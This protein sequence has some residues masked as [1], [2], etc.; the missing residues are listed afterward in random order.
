MTIILVEKLRHI[1]VHRGGR[2]KSKEAFIELVAREAGLLN[3]GKVALE[4]KGLIEQFF[5]TDKYANLVALL[6]IRVRPE[7]PIESYVCRF[8]ILVNYLMSYGFLLCEMARDYVKPAQ[9]Y[10][11]VK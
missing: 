7:W 4:S 2:A 10:P 3:N 1:V 6:E 9:A 11:V 8:G 5:G